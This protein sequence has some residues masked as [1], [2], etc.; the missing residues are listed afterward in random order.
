MAEPQIANA[1][2]VDQ[3]TDSAKGPAGDSALKAIAHLQ[4][5]AETLAAD[6][7]RL[8]EDKPEATKAI[9]KMHVAMIDG[10]MMPHLSTSRPK[11]TAPQPKPIIAN[12]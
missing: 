6:A 4:Q 11:P 1:E 7:A 10:M 2:N 8:A 3:Q 5:V 12:V 9:D